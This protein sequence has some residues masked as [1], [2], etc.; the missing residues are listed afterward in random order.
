MERGVHSGLEETKDTHSLLRPGV[1]WPLGGAQDIDQ[2]PDKFL[3]P[4]LEHP[5]PYPA[6]P[7]PAAHFPFSHHTEESWPGKLPHPCDSGTKVPVGQGAVGQTHFWESLLVA[8]CGEA[9]LLGALRWSQRE[10][11]WGG[12]GW[13]RAEG[14]GR[15][16]GS[17]GS[18][19]EVTGL[20]SQTPDSGSLKAP[21]ASGSTAKLLAPAHCLPQTLAMQQTPLHPS[22]L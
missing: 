15:R 2:R 17:T 20:G 6:S 16:R 3:H 12:C 1:P 18:C 7:F 8:E 4:P 10:I 9:A 21:A 11:F 14:R 22:K 19:G 13:V 5:R